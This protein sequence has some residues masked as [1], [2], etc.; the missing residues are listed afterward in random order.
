MA[1]KMILV[2][3]VCGD[4]AIQSAVLVVGDRRLKKD[5]CKIHLSEL[6]KGGR[7][8]GRAPGRPRRA[9][10][11]AAPPA[12]ARRSRRGTRARGPRA[13]GADVASE[14]VKLKGE[15]MTYRQIGQA[16]VERGIKPLRAKTWN[17]VVLGR[18]VKRQSAA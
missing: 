12:S 2:C 6:L 3:D 17:P 4:P 18:L 7:P 13:V 8:A 10:T 16:L 5:Y 15:G 14:V 1:E 11:A 9:P